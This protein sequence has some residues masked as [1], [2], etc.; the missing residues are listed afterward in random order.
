MTVQQ[1]GSGFGHCLSVVRDTG[2]D[3]GAV[4]VTDSKDVDR[5]PGSKNVAQ[6]TLDALNLDRAIKLRVK[7]A[8]WSEVAAECGFSS[9]AAA[10]RAV[11][12]A[13]E[14]AT[15]RATETA[16]Q[17]RNTAQMRYESLLSDT[18]KMLDADA[19]ETYDADGNPNTPDDRAVKLRAVDEARRIITDIAKLQRL[20]K[21]KDEPSEQLTV[22]LVGIDPRDIV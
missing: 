10:L 22:R 8:H 3:E 4:A 20:D 11:G 12:V 7:G 17:M 14:A 9:P 1:R 19:P 5:T 16:D 2:S 6:Q 18:L 15:Q 13:M 21:V